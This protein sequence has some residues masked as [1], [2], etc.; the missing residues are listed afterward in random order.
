M[1]AVLTAASTLHCV[2]GGR[3]TVPPGQQTLRVGGHPVLL[4]SDLASAVVTGCPNTNAS[5]G[6]KPCLTVTA[7][8]TGVSVTLRVAGQPALLA[9]AGGLTDGT[10]PT[11]RMWQVAAAGQNLLEAT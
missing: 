7:V 10:P 5:A 11:P 9:T 3:I 8:L 2:H 6:Q 4:R 1:P